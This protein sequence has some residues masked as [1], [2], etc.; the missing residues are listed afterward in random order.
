MTD[1]DYTYH[2][3]HRIIYINVKS[4]CC[5]PETNIILYVNYTLINQL[6]CLLYSVVTELNEITEEKM[7]NS[8]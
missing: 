1:G 2:D 3:E 5:T 4:L 6:E 7:S 8:V